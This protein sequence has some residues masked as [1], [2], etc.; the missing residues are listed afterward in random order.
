MSA[1]Y[2]PDSGFFYSSP[3][4]T[5]RPTGGT[6]RISIFGV[7]QD[8]LV[9]YA[10]SHDIG[11]PAYQAAYPDAMAETYAKYG[12]VFSDTDGMLVWTQGKPLT[13][14]TPSNDLRILKKV[15]RRPKFGQTYA[16]SSM[17]LVPP[18][19][20]VGQIKQCIASGE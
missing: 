13:L 17:F 12:E 7:T 19:D 16:G 18:Q 8:D 5:S 2:R 9:S 1:V 3:V 6:A 20:K 4:K 15:G 11:L 14:H 10:H